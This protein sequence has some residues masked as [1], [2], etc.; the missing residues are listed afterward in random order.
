MLLQRW[1]FVFYL[2][3]LVSPSGSERALAARYGARPLNAITAAY[4]NIYLTCT[5]PAEDV[6]GRDD[7]LP[8]DSGSTPQPMTPL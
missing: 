6:F 7:K 3:L 2:S 4:I 1:V 5:S 8:I